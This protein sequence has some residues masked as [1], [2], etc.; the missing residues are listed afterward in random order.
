MSVDPDLYLLTL[1]LKILSVCGLR[2]AQQIH[3][4][5]LMLLT[6]MIVYEKLMV[7]VEACKVIGSELIKGYTWMDH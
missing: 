4:L 3:M 7:A 1:G 6:L 2:T 5:L